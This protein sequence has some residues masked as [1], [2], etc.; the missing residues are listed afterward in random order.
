MFPKMFGALLVLA[1]VQLSSSQLKWEKISPVS[2]RTPEPRRDSAIGYDSKNDRLIIFGGRG[3][4]IFDDTWIFDIQTKKWSEVNKT[5]VP[6]P[7]MRFSM[8]FGSTSTHFYISTGE[9]SGKF[10]ADDIHRFDLSKL[11]WEKLEPRTSLKPEKRYG[12]GGGI[13]RDLEAGDEGDGFYVTHGFKDGQ[14]YSNTLKFD[15]NKKEWQEKFGGTNSYN[16]SYPHARCLHAATMTNKDE[17]VMY[18]GCLG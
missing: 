4:S 6:P 2:G 9:K 10:F 11:E 14:R 15:F 17:L 12:S 18:G 1:F 16:P 13:W 5:S 8:V 3:S 7:E